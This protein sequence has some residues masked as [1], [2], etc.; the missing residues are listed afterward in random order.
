MISCLFCS[1]ISFLAVEIEIKTQIV[2]SIRVAL[3]KDFDCL[4]E[5]FLFTTI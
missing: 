5:Q 4:L 1:Q 3:L 2:E